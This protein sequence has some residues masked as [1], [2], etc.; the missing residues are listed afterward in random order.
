MVAKVLHILS[1]LKMVQETSV[2]IINDK[3]CMIG[4]YL[5]KPPKENFPTIKKMGWGI[6]D[7][8]T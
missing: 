3:I 2:D 4:V 6:A 1:L 8:L 5:L 7:Q